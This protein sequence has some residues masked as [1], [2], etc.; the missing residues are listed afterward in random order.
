[1]GATTDHSE[2]RDPYQTRHLHGPPEAQEET[3]NGNGDPPPAFATTST[4][5]SDF[6]IGF[7]FAVLIYVSLW[8][9]REFYVD[10]V[11][12]RHEIRVFMRF[13]LPH[14][15]KCHQNTPNPTLHAPNRL[16]MRTKHLWTFLAMDLILL[17]MEEM[18]KLMELMKEALPMRR[19]APLL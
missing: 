8:I 4:E 11:D 12:F 1:L 9:S 18:E 5:T 10:F 19:S 15:A 17:P 14:H 6:S 13:G 2:H 7:G 3:P 16:E